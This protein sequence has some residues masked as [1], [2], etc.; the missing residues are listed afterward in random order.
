VEC[1][2][3]YRVRTKPSDLMMNL[4]QELATL[5]GLDENHE[6]GSGSGVDGAELESRKERRREIGEQIKALGG[7]AG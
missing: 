4:L 3:D 5:K 1:E 6:T 7:S 2:E